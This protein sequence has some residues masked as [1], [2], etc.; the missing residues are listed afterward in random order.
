MPVIGQTTCNSCQIAG[1]ALSLGLGSDLMVKTSVR[2]SL[3]NT[4]IPEFDTYFWF[5]TLVGLQCR[6]CEAA[7]MAKEIE[8]LSLTLASW[9]EFQVPGSWLWLD[10][11]QPS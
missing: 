8:L 11:Y 5:L 9:T 1:G 2:M 3:F 10:P 4:G 6:P 7:V